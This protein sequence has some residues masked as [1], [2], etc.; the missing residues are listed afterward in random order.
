MRRRRV[1]WVAVAVLLAALSSRCVGGETETTSTARAASEPKSVGVSELRRPLHV[2]TVASGR[3]PRTLGGR[4]APH[5][6][7]AL[8]SGPAY[9][10][11]GL[12]AAPP[13]RKGVVRLYANERKDGA[14]WHKI[15]WAVD[16]RYDGP[17]LIRGRGLDPPQA[18]RF[19]RPSAGVGGYEG[20][21]SELEF[22]AEESAS[23][24][25]G[26]SVTILP[27]PG[28]YAFQIDGT[29]FSKVI[30]FEAARA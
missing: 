8:G 6:A 4:P 11:P 2:P 23:W 1:D 21:V 16:P 28:C 25:Y 13:S 19:V 12:E 20:Q 26:P 27:G 14:Y 17:L 15:L 9:P 24:R 5:V 3:C 22:G 18:L 7:I 29:N 10:V 30:V